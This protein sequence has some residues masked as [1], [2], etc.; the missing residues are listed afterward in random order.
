V[1]EKYRYVKCP[2]GGAISSWPLPVGCAAA[3]GRETIAASDRAVTTL[4]MQVWRGDVLDAETG[5]RFGFAGSRI[6][7]LR[8]L[9]DIP[10]LFH[11]E[12][13]RE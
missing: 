4:R 3:L 13:E 10:G 8:R 6:L 5:W 1:S 9:V 2:R 12:V 7:V 11:R